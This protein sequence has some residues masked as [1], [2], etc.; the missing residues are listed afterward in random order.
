MSNTHHVPGPF[1]SEKGESAEGLVPPSSLVVRIPD[2]ERLFLEVR[3]AMP[4]ERIY[5]SLVTDPVTSP[6]VC[7]HIDQDVDSSIEESLK[8]EFSL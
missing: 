6:V 8:I 3:S 4:F 7:P 1:D 5:H 2:L